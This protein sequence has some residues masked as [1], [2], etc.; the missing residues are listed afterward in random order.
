M[1]WIDWTIVAVYLTWIV[2]TGLS[3]GRKQDQLEGYFLA[4]RSL[5][6][7]AVVLSLLSKDTSA[8]KIYTLSLHDAL[9][10]FQHRSHRKLLIIDE[11]AVLTGGRNIAN[12]YFDL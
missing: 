1:H 7:W 12:D 5:P 2:W 8:I 11:E 4:N 3:L 6:W 10:I 9:P